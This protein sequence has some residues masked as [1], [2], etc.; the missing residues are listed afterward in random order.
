MVS[1]H[2]ENSNGSEAQGT[3]T[4]RKLPSPS[5][6]VNS[7]QFDTILVLLTLILENKQAPQPY[8]PAATQSSHSHMPVTAKILSICLNNAPGISQQETPYKYHQ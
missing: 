1:N 2:T 6:H 7:L 8:S 3:T 5:S 4:N